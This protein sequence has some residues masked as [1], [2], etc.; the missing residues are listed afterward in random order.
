VNNAVRDGIEV[1]LVVGM[2]GMVWTAVGR[3]RRREIRVNRCS[4]C[5]RPTSAAYERC[6]WC[7]AATI[8]P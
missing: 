5:G 6:R 4:A 8:E 3:L 1:L 7:G 2:G